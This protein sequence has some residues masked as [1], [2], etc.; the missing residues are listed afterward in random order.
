MDQQTKLDT[1]SGF[2]VLIF[3]LGCLGMYLW[4][5]SGIDHC[6]SV[7]NTNCIFSDAFD[8]FVFGGLTFL[9]LIGLFGLANVLM[10]LI[11]IMGLIIYFIYF[12]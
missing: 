3:L 11:G 10:F 6:G 2:R 8:A 12:R 1:K 9:I 4:I 7:N 5:S